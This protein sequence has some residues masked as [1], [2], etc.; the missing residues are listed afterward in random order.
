MVVV[1]HNSLV[2]KGDIIV[3]QNV[4]TYITTTQQQLQLYDCHGN[5]VETFLKE[6]PVLRTSD[7]TPKNFA[8]NRFTTIPFET[9]N[10]CIT[11][12]QMWSPS[13]S[14]HCT[15]NANSSLLETIL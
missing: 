9:E 2:D 11:S 4:L 14:F 5:T 6:L 13:Y 3:L 7:L 15:I 1:K 12:K 10:L 8:P